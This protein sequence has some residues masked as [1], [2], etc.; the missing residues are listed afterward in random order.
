[1]QTR[2]ITSSSC[3]QCKKKFW[4]PYFKHDMIGD[5]GKGYT[6]GAGYTLAPTAQYLAWMCATWQIPQSSTVA[7]ASKK[8]GVWLA[9]SLKNLV[10]ILFFQLKIFIFKILYLPRVILRAC[11]VK[12]CQRHFMRGSGHQDPKFKILKRNWKEKLL[13]F[14]IMTILRL[15][16]WTQRSHRHY[17]CSETRFN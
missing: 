14:D 1:L 3:V 5:A 10:K 17:D 16:V 2:Y 9:T 6:F 8:K 4:K 13:Q 12:L 15:V 11:Q 7:E